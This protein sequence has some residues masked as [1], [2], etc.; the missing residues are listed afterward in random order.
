MEYA[1]LQ[2][3]SGQARRTAVRP[4]RVGEFQEGAGKGASTPRRFGAQQSMLAGRASPVVATEIV[5]HTFVENLR[6]A[7]EAAK[8]KGA[9]SACRVH[10]RFQHLG[11]CLN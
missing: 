7:V 2:E 5:R 9:S 1:L 4:D 11:L 6:F 8:S 10:Q 3:H